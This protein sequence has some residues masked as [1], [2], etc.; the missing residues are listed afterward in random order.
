MSLLPTIKSVTSSEEL[1][2]FNTI[3]DIPRVNA[4]FDSSTLST[5]V[6]QTPS[7]FAFV[8]T[9]WSFTSQSYLLAASTISLTG[10]FTAEGWV[11]RNVNTNFVKLSGYV[12]MFGGSDFQLNNNDQLTLDTSLSA[13]EVGISLDSGAFFATTTS[14]PLSANV[15]QHVAF[16]RNNGVFS[17]FVDGKTQPLLIKNADAPETSTVTIKML[18]QWI[19]GR[20]GQSGFQYPLGLN[21]YASNY[22]VV[23][24]YAMYTNDFNPWLNLP[25]LSTVPSPGWTPLLT[26]RTL[27]STNLSVPSN[28]LTNNNIT[29]FNTPISGVWTWK[30]KSSSQLSAYQTDYTRRPKY[31]LSSTNDLNSIVFDGTNDYFALTPSLNFTNQSTSFFV[32]GRPSFG[33]VNISFAASATNDFAFAFWSDDVVYGPEYRTNYDVLSTGIVVSAVTNSV[34]ASSYALMDRFGWTS[35]PSHW[36]DN[37]TT[38][39]NELGRRNVSSA[40]HQDRMC[41]V[42][43][44]PYLLPELEV[45]RVNEKLFNKWKAPTVAPHIGDP[46]S[47]YIYGANVNQLSSTRGTWFVEPTSINITWEFASSFSG[48]YTT[49]PDWTDTYYNL[50]P[51]DYGKFVRSRAFASNS[52]GA[53]QEVSNVLELTAIN[54]ALATL[55]RTTVFTVS[56]QLGTWVS[57][58]PY[59]RSYL[60]EISSANTVGPWDGF[61]VDTKLADYS[62]NS[63]FTTSLTAYLSSYPAGVNVR[64]TEYIVNSLH[65]LPTI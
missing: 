2:R 44:V 58:L 64:V 51:E 18:N 40:Y 37:T 39:Y 17:V 21:G 33:N 1:L 11:N 53:T 59:T 62:G 50:I 25:L 47:L 49:V 22:R 30:D 35:Q 5:V 19:A 29:M 3:D 7:V 52:A 13:N 56:T 23:A 46:N 26:M 36:R 12:S 61:N 48:P 6:F 8:D 27:S 9:I 28:S 41:E 45:R 60:W 38:V 55:E 16:V 57:T 42:I 31:I 10:D 32:Y 20:T 34:A 54:L 65:P 4:W 15:W 43:H 63:L 24:D 14:T